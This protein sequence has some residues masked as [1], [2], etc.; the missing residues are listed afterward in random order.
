MGMK[1][2]VKRGASVAGLGTFRYGV[3][4]QSFALGFHLLRNLKTA[5]A[6]SPVLP[7]ATYS[8]WLEDQAFQKWYRLARPNTL[9]DEYRCYELW[10][11]VKQAISRPG[12]ILEVGVWRGGTG[13]IIAGASKDSGKVVYLADTFSGVVKV[14]DNDTVYRDGLHSAARSIAENLVTHAGLQ[15]LQ[16]LQGTFPDDFREIATHQFC[17][18]HIDVDVYQSAKDVFE[19]VWGNM[20]RG[21]IVAFDDYGFCGCDGI[22]RYVNELAGTDKTLIHNLNGHAVVVKI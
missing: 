9:V 16:F 10:W 15:N 17:F 20:P 3:R 4:G 11:L 5:F 1:A 14:G 8:P 13:L 19:A 12:N 21:G 18:V 7:T 6:H 22:T 2:L